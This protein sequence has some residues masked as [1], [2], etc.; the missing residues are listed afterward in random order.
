M[1][2]RCRPTGTAGTI[3]DHGTRTRSCQT[4]LA[5]RRDICHLSFGIWHLSFS[6]LLVLELRLSLL[7]EGTDPLVDVLRIGQADELIRLDL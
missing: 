2:L 5:I 6:L 7:E 3:V 4:S 1:W